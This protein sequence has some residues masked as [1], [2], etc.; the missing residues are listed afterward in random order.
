MLKFLSSKAC[1]KVPQVKWVHF[2]YLT[3][4]T[5]EIITNCMFG[6]MLNAD[7]AT[8][9]EIKHA[10]A[11]RNDKLSK[12]LTPLTGWVTKTCRL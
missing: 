6:N 4:L 9:F 12:W 11:A 8:N 3:A 10:L 7:F 2:I 5:L 1:I